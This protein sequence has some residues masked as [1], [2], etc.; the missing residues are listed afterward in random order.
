MYVLIE[1]YASQKIADMKAKLSEALVNYQTLIQVAG[2]PAAEVD[3]S[4][5]Y[6]Q[7]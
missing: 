1:N 3:I 5:Q 4:R 6:F 2:H 7:A